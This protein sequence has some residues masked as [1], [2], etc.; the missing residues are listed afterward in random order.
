MCNNIWCMLQRSAQTVTRWC[1]L[2]CMGMCLFLWHTSQG[3]HSFFTLM[4]IISFSLQWG[5]GGRDHTES[6]LCSH[7]TWNCIQTF[8]VHEHAWSP[9][10]WLSAGENTRRAHHWNPVSIWW[11]S[12]LLITH[13]YHDSTNQGLVPL[14]SLIHFL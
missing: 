14:P 4:P 9:I 2:G 1:L 10:C 13:K 8:L 11:T 12:V 3:W 6:R 5:I 7:S